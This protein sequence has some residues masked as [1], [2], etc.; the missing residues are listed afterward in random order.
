V[1]QGVPARPASGSGCRGRRD[2]LRSRMTRASPPENLDQQARQETQRDDGR[3][4]QSSQHHDA[5]SAIELRPSA[6]DQDQRRETED[7]RQP[8]HQDRPQSRPPW[9]PS[10]PWPRWFPWGSPCHLWPPAGLS[11]GRGYPG[12]G[13]EA[14][15]G[16]PRG[17]EGL[18]GAGWS[19]W[20]AGEVPGR[21]SGVAPSIVSGNRWDAHRLA[22]RARMAGERWCNCGATAGDGQR[23]WVTSNTLARRKQHATVTSATQS[24]VRNAKDVSS[25]LLRSSNGPQAS[26]TRVRLSCLRLRRS[27]LHWHP[28]PGSSVD[29][30]TAS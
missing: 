27:P 5:E 8:R 4:D 26:R 3:A 7:R 15:R 17:P 24:R 16:C 12:E 19:R 14:S 25:I 13:Q 23:E 22:V 10:W 21:S 28:G 1:E 9:P 6:R 2:G 18:N 29:R 20:R 11:T 30:A